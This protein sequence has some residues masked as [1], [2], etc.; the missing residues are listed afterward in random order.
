MS[1]D[2]WLQ[3]AFRAKVLALTGKEPSWSEYPAWRKAIGCPLPA[4]DDM[5]TVDDFMRRMG[6]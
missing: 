4:S 1:A 6:L 5:R 2:P 3:I